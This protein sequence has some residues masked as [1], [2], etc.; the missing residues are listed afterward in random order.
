MIG[1]T[2]TPCV[3][4]AMAVPRL[5]AGKLSSSTA[6]AM[7]TIAPPP[8]PCKMRA[9][10]SIGRFNATP[11]NTEANVNIAMHQIRTRLRPNRFPSQPVIGRMMALATR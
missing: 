10:I 1:A 7:G 2:T 11:H 4:M 3:K 6:C 9:R 5:F 8:A